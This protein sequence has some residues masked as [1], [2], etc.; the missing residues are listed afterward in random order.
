MK[1]DSN[2]LI[3]SRK[4]LKMTQQE[5]AE[6]L[7]VAKNYIYLMES[8]RKP[9]TESVILGIEKLD[10]KVRLEDEDWRLR[11]LKAERQ[12]AEINDALSLIIEGVTKL[13]EAIK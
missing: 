11:A 5:V 1:K 4:A 10:P 2:W 8:G 9:V 6:A 7:G 12:L 13:Q 3:S